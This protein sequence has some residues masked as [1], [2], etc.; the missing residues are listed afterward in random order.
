M[1]ERLDANE[2]MSS[3]FR[4]YISY[5]VN[6]SNTIGDIDEDKNV[7]LHDD[8]I[9]N[10]ISETEPACHKSN[11]PSPKKN[12][13]DSCQSWNKK[14]ACIVTDTLLYMSGNDDSQL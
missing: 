8:C 13:D 5:L 6:R 10:S 11:T 3:L 9:A 2:K 7:C 1:N 14:G 12:S 4:K